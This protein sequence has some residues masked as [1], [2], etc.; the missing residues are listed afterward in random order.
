MNILCL[1]IGGT[2]T[3]AALVGN[4]GLVE[5]KVEKTPQANSDAM[6]DLSKNLINDL[7]KKKLIKY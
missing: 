3:R 6:L 5:K 7:K 2:H 4:D 1:D